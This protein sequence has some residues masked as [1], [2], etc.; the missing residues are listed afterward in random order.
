MISEILENGDLKLIV[1]AEDQELLRV[2]QAEDPDGFCSD[3]TMLD[4]FDA[5]IGNSEYE[6]I[7]PEEVGALTSAP[8][9]GM[10]GLERVRKNTDS[11]SIRVAGSWDNRVWVLDVVSCWAFMD[12]QIVSV[13]ERLLEIGE[14]VFTCGA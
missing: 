12:Y 9:L 1:D 5:F 6:W 11:P 14:V 4:W 10:Y 13:Q 3:N 7:I 2:L 8:M